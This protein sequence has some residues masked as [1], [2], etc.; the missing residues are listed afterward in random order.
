MDWLKRILG[1]H[2]HERKVFCVGNIAFVKCVTCGMESIPW[3]VS[4]EKAKAWRESYPN[5]I[6]DLVAIDE[7]RKRPASR[8]GG[9]DD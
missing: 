4:R 8:K 1:I 9:S 7:R 3:E 6:D 5:A 2:S